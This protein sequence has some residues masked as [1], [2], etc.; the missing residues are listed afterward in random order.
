MLR[1]M[2]R[3]DNW[4]DVAPLENMEEDHSFLF[5]KKNLMKIFFLNFENLNF[6]KELKILNF[7]FWKFW[8]SWIFEG[9]WKNLID[10]IFFCFGKWPKKYEPNALSP[11]AIFE[12]FF[13]EKFGSLEFFHG[14]ENFWLIFFFFLKNLEILNFFKELKI[15]NFF[16]WKKPKKYEPNAPSPKAFFENFVFLFFFF[17]FEIWRFV[18]YQKSEEDE[19]E[20]GVK[21]MKIYS[22]WIFS[23]FFEKP[24]L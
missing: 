17:F 19:D 1:R 12:F 10:E 23:F 18:H 9:I 22:W 3:V 21:V 14:I 8:K 24:I 16:F 15:L 20:D 2:L 7:F 13:F 11:K 5:L 4:L 6:S